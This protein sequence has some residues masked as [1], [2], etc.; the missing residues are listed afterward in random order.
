MGLDA[1][2]ASLFPQ[3]NNNYDRDDEFVETQSPQSPHKRIS[4]SLKNL[5]QTKNLILLVPSKEKWELC[6]QVINQEHMHTPLAILM[7]KAGNR[8]SL[9]ITDQ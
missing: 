9:H 8:L 1:H 2:I 5:L 7:K 4:R 3:A 6:Q